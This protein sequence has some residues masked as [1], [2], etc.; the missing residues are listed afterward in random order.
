MN[1]VIRYIVDQNPKLP[2]LKSLTG[3]QTEEYFNERIQLFFKDN[4]KIPQQNL[5][6]KKLLLGNYLF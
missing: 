6:L 1:D 3:K 4:F 2:E 5:G